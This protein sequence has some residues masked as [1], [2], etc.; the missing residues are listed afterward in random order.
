MNIKRVLVSSEALQE[1]VCR[2]AERIN[3]AYADT[4]TITALIVLEGA[5]C[6]AE[7]LLSNIDVPFEQE[8]IKI[9]TYC[10][11]HSG[12]TTVID[13]DDKLHEKLRGK[14]ILVI[15]D[16]YDTGRTLAALLH[17]LEDCLPRSIKT[18]VLLEKEIQHCEKIAIDFLG[19][20]VPNVFVVGYGMD[21]NGQFRELPFIA[22]F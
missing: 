1:T 22:E 6:F 12:C 5:R 19:A 2:L 14:D 18:C 16:I 11:T 21:F 3:A 4:D 8:Y 20:K 9:S 13:F 17:C 10:G 15:D 7:N